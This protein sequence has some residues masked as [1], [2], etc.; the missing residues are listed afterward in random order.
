LGKKTVLKVGKI[1]GYNYRKK[2]GLTRK[3]MKRYELFHGRKFKMKNIG[4]TKEFYISQSGIKVSLS[5]V[6]FGGVH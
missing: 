2:G 6:Y 4:V 3:V 1:G 5:K